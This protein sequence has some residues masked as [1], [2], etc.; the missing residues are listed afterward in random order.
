MHEMTGIGKW[1]DYL[2]WAYE[3]SGISPSSFMTNEEL[4]KVNSNWNNISEQINNEYKC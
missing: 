2:F 1:E 3:G 4:T